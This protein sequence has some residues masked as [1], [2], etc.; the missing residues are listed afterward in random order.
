MK[1]FD[2]THGFSGVPFVPAVQPRE[3]YELPAGK[4]GLR[5]PALLPLILFDVSTLILVSIYDKAGLTAEKLHLLCSLE[6]TLSPKAILP[7]PKSSRARDQA[8]RHA[9]QAYWNDPY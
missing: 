8:T 4:M 6:P 1:S 5:E 7:S 9:S 3:G 2:P